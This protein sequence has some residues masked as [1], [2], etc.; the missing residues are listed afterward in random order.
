MLRFLQ[1]NALIRTATAESVAAGNHVVIARSG[2]YYLKQLCHTFQYAEECM[3]DTAIE[4]P[5]VWER[6]CELTRQVEANISIAD[7]MVVRRTRIGVFMDYLVALE[8]LMLDG[9]TGTGHLRLLAAVS[10]DVKKEAYRA[11]KGAAV[12]YVD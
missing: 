4:D 11:M 12:R 3:L 2:G 10:E 9:T 5:A 7:R 1:G 6:L 8:Q